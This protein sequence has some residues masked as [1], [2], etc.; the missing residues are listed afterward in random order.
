MKLKTI[1]LGLAIAALMISIVSAPV[2][3]C[4]YTPG[5]WKHNVRVHEGGPGRYS[6]DDNGFKETDALM[7]WYEDW[8]RTNIPGQSG[9]TLGWANTQF[10]MRGHGVQATR[11]MIADWFNEAKAAY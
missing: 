10:W 4:D 9:F 2:L 1:A 5:Y 3:A 6:A 7:E 11:Q 8:I